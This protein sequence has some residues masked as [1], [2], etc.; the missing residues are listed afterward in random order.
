MAPH[1]TGPAQGGPK[2][3]IAPIEGRDLMDFCYHSRSPLS[4]WVGLYNPL[5]GPYIVIVNCIYRSI[6]V[7]ETRLRRLSLQRFGGCPLIVFLGSLP[8]FGIPR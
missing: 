8:T 7:T 3:Q 4:Q 1:R 5:V 2:T 6:N